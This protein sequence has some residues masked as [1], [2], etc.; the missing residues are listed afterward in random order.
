[1]NLPPGTLQQAAKKVG[2]LDKVKEDD[3]LKQIYMKIKVKQEE[4]I[5]R[6]EGDRN[7]V[8][9]VRCDNNDVYSDEEM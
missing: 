2:L 8:E 5:A 4:A 9:P 6:L 1:L 3:V 7:S